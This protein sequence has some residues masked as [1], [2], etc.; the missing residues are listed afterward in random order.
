MGV[1]LADMLIISLCSVTLIVFR[2][3]FF[4]SESWIVLKSSIFYMV[5]GALLFVP[6]NHR[7]GLLFSL[8]G[9]RLDLGD[10][11]W[12]SYR[13]VMGTSYILYAAILYVVSE[14]LP[15]TYWVYTK[16]YGNLLVNF[17]LS[18]VVGV[19]VIQKNYS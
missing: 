3:V 10:I 15:L 1:V 7:K 17:V 4:V 16:V 19:I 11:V 5:V 13:K 18:I 2:D 6:F 8:W 12:C 14:T 9:N